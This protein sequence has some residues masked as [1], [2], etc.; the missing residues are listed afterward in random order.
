MKIFIYIL[1]FSF[2]T[3]LHSQ[4]FL[5]KSKENTE[6]GFEND[7]EKK[8][9][10]DY[11]F[12]ALK[13]RSLE[14]Y[15]E[16]IS[17]FQRCL[18][19]NNKHAVVFYELAK[20]YKIQERYFL[21]TNNIEQAILLEST[22]Y[23]FLIL[24]AELL[25]MQGDYIK[26]AEQYKT[27]ID[28]QPNNQQLYFMLAEMY[29]Y[30]KKI[31]KAIQVYNQIQEKTGVDKLLSMQ[32]HSL[33][34]QLKDFDGALNELELLIK[35][36][37]EDIEAMEMLSEL[38]LLNNEQDKAFE[39]FKRISL[40]DPNNGRIQLTLADYYRQSGDNEASYKCLKLAFSS[41]DLDLDTKISVL[42]S[43]YRL[44]GINNEIT[45]QAYELANILLNLYPEEVK[46]RAVY[47]DILYTNNDID[48]AKEQ[49]LKILEK[50]KS[51]SEV[52]SQVM[53][54]QAQSGEFEELLK[55]SGRALEYFPLNPLFY[56]FNGVS[57]S[58]LEIHDKAIFSF[59]S[60]LDFIINNQELLIEINLSLADS[61]HKTDQHELS[62]KHFEK[63]LSLDPENTIVLNNYAYYLSLR[64]INLQKAKT[65]SFRCNELEPKNS[66]Y[67]DTYAW[68]LYQ[69]ED[70][71][72][73][74]TWLEKALQNGGDLSPVIIEHY[75][76]VLY[77]LGDID[78][79]KKQ[80]KKALDL[81]N[82]G[83]FLYKKANEGVFYE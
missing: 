71:K 75:G 54:I 58:R 26:A 24:Y 31:K 42:I 14:N 79:A 57:N 16:A 9:F 34:I 67:Q 48:E 69:L 72:N 33:Y 83:P 49:Y 6:K 70:Y 76:D 43:Y 21:S 3:Q 15:E 28:I 23:W 51:K 80:W 11:F 64:K 62:D 36:F 18:E 56:Y 59:K 47:A 77:K 13:A 38:Y 53:F 30:A 37:P 68:V 19:I 17:A 22:N 61:Y 27:L 8:L 41:L 32:K 29:V 78:A 45:V 12:S 4:A 7:L 82:A 44:I 55:T 25:Y 40:L 74:K 10:E 20:I 50:D 60:G 81:G 73:A 52:W 1:L 63:V 39:L 35:T 46:A 5:N 2:S 65:M 66:T